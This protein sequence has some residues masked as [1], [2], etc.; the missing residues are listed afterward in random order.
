MMN[1]WRWLA[2]LSFMFLLSQCKDSGNPIDDELTPCPPFEIV[3]QPAYDSPI[4]HPS[5]EFIGF[6]HTPLR[7]IEYPYGEHCQGVQYFQGDSAGFWLINPDGANMR[8]IFPYPLQ[9]PSWSPDG[10]WIAFVLD[11]QI[12]KMRFTGTTF[13]TTTMVQ[14]TFEGRNFFPAWSPDGQWIAYSN[15]IGDTVGVWISPT[16][17]SNSRTYF[18]YGSQPD[19]FP[20]GQ[21]IVYGNKGV[22]IEKLDHSSKVQIY[23]DTIRGG[24]CIKVSPDASKIALSLNN[25]VWVMDSS[26]TNIAQLT[27]EGI[28]GAFGRPLCWSPSGGQIVYS[29]YRPDNWGYQNGVLWVI[30]PLTSEKRQLD[31]PP[32]LRTQRKA[33]ILVAEGG[34]QWKESRNGISM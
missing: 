26:G 2:L 18:A 34:P 5:G 14:L 21:S 31:L 8:R 15:S 9:T 30:N 12:F 28:D 25:N 23:A 17:G 29:Q 3:P 20:D 27:T 19:W 1:V 24:N 6:N 11:A 7:K 4:W 33:T 10:E 13:D 16:N 32:I 22:W